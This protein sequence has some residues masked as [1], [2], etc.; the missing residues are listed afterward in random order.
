MSKWA[1]LAIAGIW[2]G[3]GIISFNIDDISLLIVAGVAT[4]LTAFFDTMSNGIS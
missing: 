3:A 4:G 1:G 2:I